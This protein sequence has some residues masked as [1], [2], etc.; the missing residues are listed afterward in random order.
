MN[1]ISAIDFLKNEVADKT[2]ELHYIQQKL[3]ELMAD[4]NIETNQEG[5]SLF[6]STP[7]IDEINASDKEEKIETKFIEKR[8]L[9][10][11][12]KKA[13]SAAIIYQQT[14]ASKLGIKD[15]TIGRYENG[16]R[17]PSYD[18]LIKV[19]E[20]LNC[21]QEWLRT[22]NGIA[23]VIPSINKNGLA[24]RI[25]QALRA[26]NITLYA[27]KFILPFD[28]GL[29]IYKTA[30][31]P[32]HKLNLIAQVLECDPEWLRTGSG[33]APKILAINREGLGERIKKAR[34]ASKFTL[35]KLSKISGIPYNSIYQYECGIYMPTRARLNLIANSLHI[36][37]EW[38]IT[39]QGSTQL[40][41]LSKKKKLIENALKGSL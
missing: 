14:L 25:K 6:T 41:E 16:K 13:R 36:D 38:L 3:K 5:D 28:I 29:Y 23:P 17:I 37:A 1:P 30:N 20:I 32:L 24:L 8:G 39:G 2:V 11:R 34:R 35:M 19:S 7:S 31:P 18:R 40:K 12:L 33:V 26:K 21:D 15:S 27:A 10:E 22:G 4:I 9:S